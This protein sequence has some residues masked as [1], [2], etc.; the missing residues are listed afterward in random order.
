MDPM[1]LPRINQQNFENE[2]LRS[3]LPVLIDVSTAWCAPC[4]LA[5]SAV[6]E[7]AQQHQGQLK[8]VAI[9]GDESPELVASLGVRG[10]PTFLGYVGGK[11]V[12]SQAGFYG[13]KKLAELSERL[14]GT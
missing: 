8:V 2:V 4:R 3:E 13:K 11:R 5:A 6:A 7:V 14:I 9:D 1:N 12:E 10:Y